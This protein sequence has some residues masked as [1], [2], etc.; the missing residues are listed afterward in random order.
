M[1]ITLGMGFPLSTFVGRLTLRTLFNKNRE[2]GA[3]PHFLITT[4]WVA[5]ALALA[6]GLDSIS[7]VFNFVG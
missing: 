2:F 1:C 5:L 3:L 7:V 6:V 4:V